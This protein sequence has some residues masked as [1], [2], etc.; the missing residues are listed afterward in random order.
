LAAVNSFLMVRL[1]I[2]HRFIRARFFRRRRP[3]AFA[4]CSD[5]GMANVCFMETGL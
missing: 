5:I 4:V 3:S 1:E 2:L